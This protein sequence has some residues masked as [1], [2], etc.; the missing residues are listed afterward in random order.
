MSRI[1]DRCNLTILF[2]PGHEDLAEFLA[3]N[4]VEITASLPCYQ[5][6][7]VDEQRGNGTFEKSIAA[8]QKLNGMGYGK[9]QTGLVLNLVYNPIGVEFAPPE[10]ELERTYKQELSDRFGVTFNRLFAMNNMPIN[11]FRDGLSRSGRLPDYMGRTVGAFNLHAMDGLMCKHMISV[12]WDGRLHDCD[13]N[14]ALDIPLV[15]GMPAHIGEF[16]L[17]LTR[18]RSINTGSHC[19]TCA[20]GAGSSCSGALADDSIPTPNRQELCHTEGVRAERRQ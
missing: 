6:E 20:A 9:S 12:G 18:K 17:A 15:A 8:L 3:E 13:F 16:D 4:G 19:F 2:E 1:V 10:P 11:R 14:Q 5:A 7:N